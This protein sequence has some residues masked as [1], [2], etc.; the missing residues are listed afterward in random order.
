MLPPLSQLIIN[1][2]SGPRQVC[3]VDMTTKLGIEE[4]RVRQECVGEKNDA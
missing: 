3:L 1:Q 2:A 4:G